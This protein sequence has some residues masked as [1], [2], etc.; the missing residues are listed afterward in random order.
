VPP[1]LTEADHQTHFDLQ[2]AIDGVAVFLSPLS[3]PTAAS[4]TTSATLA[5]ASNSAATQF[6]SLTANYNLIEFAAVSSHLASER[7]VIQFEDGLANWQ[8]LFAGDSDFLANLFQLKPYLWQVQDDYWVKVTPV[9]TGTQYT[10]LATIVNQTNFLSSLGLAPWLLL[11]FLLIIIFFNLVAFSIYY[12]QFSRRYYFTNQ[13]K[14]IIKGGE[15]SLLEFKSSLRFDRNTKQLNKILEAAVLKSIAAFNNS[16]GGMLIVGVDDKGKVLGL[17]SDYETLKKSDK[18]G[19]EL[20]LRALISQAYGE[21]FAARRVEIIFSSLGREEVCLIRVRKGRTPLYTL[22][23]DKNG[24][25]TE[26]FYIRL[27]NSSREIEKPSDIVAYQ[28]DR[29]GRR[30]RLPGKK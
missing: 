19:F 14:E 20:H 7:A 1:L 13:I 23:T 3:S 27:G 15:N 11:V 8:L 16:D 21:H 2:L 18:D 10:L 25:K 4:S 6:F 28:K 24:T 12:V 26:K 29:F 22:A 17:K 9:V 5:S 30:L